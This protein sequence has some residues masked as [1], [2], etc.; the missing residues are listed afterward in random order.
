MRT[1]LFGIPNHEKKKKK[2]IIVTNF[3]SKNVK[4]RKN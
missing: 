1:F 4:G 3:R 2:K